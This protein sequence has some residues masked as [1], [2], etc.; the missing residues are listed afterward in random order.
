MSVRLIKFLPVLGLSLLGAIAPAASFTNIFIDGVLAGPGNPTLFGSSG[1]TFSLPSHFLLGVGTKSLTLDY[2][3]TADPGK[4]LTAFSMFPTGVARNGTVS[5]V[6]SH[7]NGST[8]NDTY[9]FTAGNSLTTLPNSLNN[10]LNGMTQYDVHAVI[11]LVGAATNSVNKVTIYS[12]SYTE[13]VPEPA[14]LAAISLGLGALV[15][16]RRRNIKS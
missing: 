10:G 9:A 13:S 3:V 15:A 8:Q 4:S 6:N 2:R 16:R 14:S 5:I 11:N 12:V 1:L 7:T